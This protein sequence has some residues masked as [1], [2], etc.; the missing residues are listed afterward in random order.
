MQKKFKVVLFNPDTL[1]KH[2]AWFTFQWDYNNHR[3]NV[4][5][6]TLFGESDNIYTGKPEDC[7]RRYADARNVRDK[8]Y[9]TIKTVAQSHSPTDP[10]KIIIWVLVCENK[11]KK[12]LAKPVQVNIMSMLS[13]YTVY[14][15]IENEVEMKVALASVTER[16]NPNFG[17]ADAPNKDLQGYID[18]EWRRSDGRPLRDS[19]SFPQGVNIL[20]EQLLAQNPELPTCVGLDEL[21]KFII[22]NKTEFSCWAYVN[23]TD[24][25]EYRNYGFRK[26]EPKPTPQYLQGRQTQSGTTTPTEQLPF[27]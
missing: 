3:W 6:R 17:K 5:L 18:F 10:D 9:I 15:P 23:H 27:A 12:G 21:V 26:P 1:R 24:G 2:E 8:E 25:V 11:I 22:E 19:R 7:V 16:P 14:A 13:S 4:H 20:I